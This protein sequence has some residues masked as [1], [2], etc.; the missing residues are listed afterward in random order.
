MVSVD[1]V[2]HSALPPAEAWARVTDWPGH[3]DVVPL[4]QVRLTDDGICARTSLGPLGFDDPMRIV[5]QQPPTADAPGECE[6]VK[7]GRVFHGWAVLTVTPSGTGSL[8]RWQESARV[9]PRWLRTLTGPVQDVFATVL[10]RR[11]L[12]ALLARPVPEHP[13][14]EHPAP[15]RPTADGA[16]Q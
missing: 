15:E 12:R 2:L 1:I 16:S 8:I 9:G 3:A 6:L 5:S 14:P 4:T 10:F 7:T 11:V 13:A